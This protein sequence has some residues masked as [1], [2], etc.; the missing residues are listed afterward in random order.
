MRGTV[1][2]FD[3]LGNTGAITGYDARRYEFVRL[4]WHA[5]G[6]PVRGDLVDFVEQGQRATQIY[7]VEPADVP[8]SFLDFY[9]TLSGRASRSQYW[10]RL[11]LPVSLLSLLLDA[12][13]SAGEPSLT[14]LSQLFRVLALWPGIAVLV[15]RIHDRDKPGWLVWALYGPLIPCVVLVIGAFVA[16]GLHS[17]GLAAVLGV[18]AAITGFVACGVAIWFFIEFGCLRGTVG[19]NRYGPD[20]VRS[21]R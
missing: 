16:V 9:F 15:K 2:G 20:P 5:E 1:L 12:I 14:V 18:A 10:L 13:A 11:I 4:D 6:Q 3:P 8:Q 21:V 19:A 7:R 17:N